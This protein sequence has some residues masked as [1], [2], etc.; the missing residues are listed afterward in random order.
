MQHI[1][2]NNGVMYDGGQIKPMWAFLKFG[3]KGS[4]IVTW[5]GPM[6]VKSDQI[7]DYEDLGL[8][9]KANEMLHFIVEHFDTQPA[10]IRLI[11]HRQRIL[12]MITKDL[13]MEMGIETQRKGDDIYFAGGKL[14][15]SIA[16]CSASSMKIHLGIN[17]ITEGT[18]D[19]IPTAGLLEI[20]ND[21]NH[22]K[23]QKLADT[24]CIRYKEEINSIEEDIAK[25]RVF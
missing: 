7:I 10:D 22:E 14:S 11:Y 24:I 8:E 4:N 19:N 1:K 23:V 9:I 5:L 12:V 17:L 6:K 15:V 16:T 18:P 2:L 3:I 25:T 20:S 21:L 13:L